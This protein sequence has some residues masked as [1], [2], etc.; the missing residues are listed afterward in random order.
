SGK[1]ASDIVAAVHS[2]DIQGEL[3]LKD[4]ADYR[5]LEK[6]AVCAPF[7]DYRIC[8]APPA[9]S[10]GVAM[11][12]IMGLYDLI[13][14]ASPDST[15]EANLRDFVLAQQLGYADRDHYVADPD[16]VS[17]PVDD[18]LNPTYLKARAAQGFRPGD[19]P[20]PG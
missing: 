3:S 10:G 8:S 11:N 19:A 4:L 5:V 9:S 1:I 18:L 7:R 12:Q 13:S 6:P 20:Q 15:P 14:A 16:A 17:V 2:G